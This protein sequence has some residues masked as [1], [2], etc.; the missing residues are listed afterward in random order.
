MYTLILSVFNRITN[1]R[2]RDEG[3][4]MRAFQSGSFQ[5]F[6]ILRAMCSHDGNVT[7]TATKTIRNYAMVKAQEF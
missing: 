1:A 3:H 5:L 2:S 7:L 6:S 4:E